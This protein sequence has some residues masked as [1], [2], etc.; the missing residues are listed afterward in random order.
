MQAV[1]LGSLR[2]FTQSFFPVNA[3]IPLLPPTGW[4]ELHYKLWRV[5][6]SNVL[7]SLKSKGIRLISSAQRQVG[8]KKVAE[9]KI[10]ACINVNS[11]LQLKT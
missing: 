5:T 11:K 4:W 8:G 3:E 6:M 10:T 2:S 7:C 9:N 1:K